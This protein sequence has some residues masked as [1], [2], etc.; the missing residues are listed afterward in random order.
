MSND[1]PL[2]PADFDGYPPTDPTG[3]VDVNL[4]DCNLERTP[5]QRLR[6]LDECARFVLGLRRN[7]IERHG[8][9]PSDLETPE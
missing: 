9:D 2:D 4:L 5:A 6:Q 8:F 7:F 1:G 3:T